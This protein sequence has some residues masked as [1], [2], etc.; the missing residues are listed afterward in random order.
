[1]HVSVI[2]VSSG[3][4]INNEKFQ[5]YAHNT[6]RLFV[7]TYPWYNMPTT[8]HKFFIHGPEIVS[9]ALL[10]IEQLSEVGDAADRDGLSETV[11]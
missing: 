8:L 1:M 11:T 4:E 5:I 9:N 7:E 3:H 10:H 2:A 6:G